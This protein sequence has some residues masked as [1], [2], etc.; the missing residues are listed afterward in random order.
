MADRCVHP[1]VVQA[2]VLQETLQ[3]LVLLTRQQ[4]TLVQSLGQV[5]GAGPAFVYGVLRAGNRQ[6]RVCVADGVR[7]LV[8]VSESAG[9][10][11][12]LPVL[13]AEMPAVVS[14][15]QVADTAPDGAGATTAGTAEAALTFGRQTEQYWQLVQALISLS[16]SATSCAMLCTACGPVGCLLQTFDGLLRRRPIMEASSASHDHVL[17]GLLRAAAAVADVM[18]RV[19]CSCPPVD[20]AAG[21]QWPQISKALLHYVLEECLF[22]P[23][24]VADARRGAPRAIAR[25]TSGVAPLAPPKCKSTA[26]RDAGFL[27]LGRLTAAG[28]GSDEDPLALENRLMEAVEPHHTEVKPPAQSAGWI[29]DLATMEK[30]ATGWVWHQC[31][32]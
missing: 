5:P 31:C 20:A 7:S 12:F 15:Y 32:A 17:E 2:A 30:S 10:A 18:A 21:A 3:L 24:G 28:T 6:L 22:S 4:P 25:A 29:F 16:A 27:L 1:C 23:P 11:Y 9:L 19:G 26:S 13:M 14:G 8:G